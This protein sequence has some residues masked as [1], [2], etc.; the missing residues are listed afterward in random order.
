MM[1]RYNN[2]EKEPR[3]RMINSSFDANFI[4]TLLE[5][6]PDR[7]YYCGP[8]SIEHT[9]RKVQAESKRQDIFFY[10]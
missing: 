2:E 4:R 10:I 3:I 9:I 6:Q 1:L 8:P 5:K 7:L